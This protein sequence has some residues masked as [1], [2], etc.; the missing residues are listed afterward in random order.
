MYHSIF[1]HSLSHF[2]HRPPAASSGSPRL[3]QHPPTPAPP[4]PFPSPPGSSN[5]PPRLL[6]RALPR[7]HP[8]PSHPNSLPSSP[9]PPPPFSPPPSS[10]LPSPYIPLPTTLPLFPPPP[11]RSRRYDPLFVRLGRPLPNQSLGG[12]GPGLRPGA[13]PRHGGA[14]AASQKVRAAASHPNTVAFSRL[15]ISSRLVISSGVF[16]KA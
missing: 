6:L 3:T 5:L 13:A 10:P 14:Q 8:R 16:T 1:T 12:P 4:R 15:R 7:P 2:F 11:R 9:A